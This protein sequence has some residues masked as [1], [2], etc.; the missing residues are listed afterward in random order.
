MK[1]VLRFILGALAAT[2]VFL[3]LFWFKG[4]EI[5]VLVSFGI[6]SVAVVVTL[7]HFSK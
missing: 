7:F 2:G 6:T 4:H 3:V 1:E 5:T